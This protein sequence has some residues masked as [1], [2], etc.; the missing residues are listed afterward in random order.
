MTIT[1]LGAFVSEQYF[2]LSL[3]RSLRCEGRIAEV[4]G[5]NPYKTADGKL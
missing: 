5:R 1:L 2:L 3:L 4:E